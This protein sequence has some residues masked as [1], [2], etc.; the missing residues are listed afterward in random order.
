MLIASTLSICSTAAGWLEH[1]DT[2]TNEMAQL[3]IA[4]ALNLMG[5]ACQN[6]V[7]RSPLVVGYEIYVSAR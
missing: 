4:A 2:N 1:P 3:T 5:E 6:Y 7:D